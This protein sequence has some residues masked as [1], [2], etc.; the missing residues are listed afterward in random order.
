MTHRVGQLV[1]GLA[2]LEDARRNLDR[3]SRSALP[4][5]NVSV[6]RLAYCAPGATGRV[7]AA[8][9]SFVVPRAQGKRDSRDGSPPE[10]A[11]LI[12]LGPSGRLVTLH[13]PN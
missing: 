9:L 8:N 10:A 11:G 1:E 4:G 6:S 12:I 5:P 13:C 7:L 3:R 2:E